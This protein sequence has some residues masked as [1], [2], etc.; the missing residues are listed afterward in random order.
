MNENVLKCKHPEHEPNK[1]LGCN[2]QK[3]ADILSTE[4]YKYKII[5]KGRC[6]KE[7][8]CT[9]CGCNFEVDSTD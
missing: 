6:F 4:W 8:C 1:Y 5:D 7:Y 2:S 3:V 9:E